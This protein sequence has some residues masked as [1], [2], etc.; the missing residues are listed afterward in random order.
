MRTENQLGIDTRPFGNSIYPDADGLNK[1]V[2]ND[3]YLESIIPRII[4]RYPNGT[5]IR[6]RAGQ[7]IA[8][9]SG[10]VRVSKKFKGTSGIIEIKVPITGAGKGTRPI[11]TVTPETR[12]PSAAYIVGWTPGYKA[13]KVRISL[14][15][16]TKQTTAILYWQMF[17]ALDA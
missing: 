4:I 11:L 16:R 3:S 10:M 5:V 1:L 9:V 6:S 17:V 8:L 15:D 13:A 14:F 7:D 2:K 12:Y